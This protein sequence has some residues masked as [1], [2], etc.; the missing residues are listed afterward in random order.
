M[1]NETSPPNEEKA[2]DVQLIHQKQRSKS[3]GLSMKWVDP[4]VRDLLPKKERALS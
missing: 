4:R 2:L 3:S 1:S